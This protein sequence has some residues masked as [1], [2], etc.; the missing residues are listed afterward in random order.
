MFVLAASTYI[1]INFTYDRGVVQ[2]NYLRGASRS[3][4]LVGEALTDALSSQVIV[5]RL[6]MQAIRLFLISYTYFELYE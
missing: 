5:L 1:I 6:C 2:C 4:L 3:R